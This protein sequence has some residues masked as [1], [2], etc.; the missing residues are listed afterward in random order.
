LKKIIL[1]TAILIFSTSLGVFT[2]ALAQSDNVDETET[3][4][5]FTDKACPIDIST[6]IIQ[7]KVNFYADLERQIE[8]PEL[9]SD[10]IFDLYEDYQ[11]LRD[12]MQD[13]AQ[14]IPTESAFLKRNYI[15]IE[16][17]DNLNSRLDEVQN[18]LHELNSDLGTFN[19]QMLCFTESCIQR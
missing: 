2:L 10:R 12:N 18:H 19:N 8:S 17:Y 5:V 3:S 16:K 11:N 15:L 13:L 9:T 4:V 7:F 1:I 14:T 6:N